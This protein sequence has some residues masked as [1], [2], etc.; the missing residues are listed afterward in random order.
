MSPF[1]VSDPGRDSTPA[2]PHQVHQPEAEAVSDPAE[3]GAS[4]GGRVRRGQAQDAL[5]G[6][7]ER[8]A[9]RFREGRGSI[10]GPLKRLKGIAILKLWELE[11]GIGHRSRPSTA[12][13]TKCTTQDKVIKLVELVLVK[14]I[15]FLPK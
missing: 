3:A 9:A 2:K 7:L 5:V 11:S 14:F 1:P 15:P 6:Q 12:E 13:G 10:L 8:L 4:F